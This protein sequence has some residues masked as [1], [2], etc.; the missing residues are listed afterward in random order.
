MMADPCRREGRGDLPRRTPSL[1]VKATIFRQQALTW[2]LVAAA[3]PRG[4]VLDRRW[5][6]EERRSREREGRRGA[7]SIRRATI[8]R[9]RG[10]GLVGEQLVD[11][12]V[13]A[14]PMLP[15]WIRCCSRQGF[16]ELRRS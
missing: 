1:C 8:C 16:L 12:K 3:H 6:P 5:L 15:S 9:N 14:A 4:R 2:R 11:P 10:A 13:R 7:L